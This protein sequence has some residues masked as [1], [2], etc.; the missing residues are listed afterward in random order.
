MRFPEAIRR[1]AATRPEGLPGARAQSALSPRPRRVWDTDVV[2]KEAAGLVLI[3]PRSGEAHLLLTLRGS[4]VATHRG[5]VALPGGAIEPG[6]TVED[7]ALREAREEIGLDPSSVR[8]W[9]RLTPLRIPVSGFVLRPVVATMGIAPLVAPVGGEVARI[10]EI[11]LASLV[12]G[13]LEIETR[14]RD[15]VAIEIPYFDVDGAKLWGA[16]AMVVAELLS[17]LGQPLG[18]GEDDQRTP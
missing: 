15:G 12:A 3:F 1:L 4:G 9:L 7:A 5:Q 16:T 14:T 13:A 11:P 6:E 18:A 2:P 17:V 10:L 8:V